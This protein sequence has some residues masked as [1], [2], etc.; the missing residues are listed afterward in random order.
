MRLGIVLLVGLL[1]WLIVLC[2]KRFVEIRRKQALI[3]AIPYYSLQKHYGVAHTP[4]LSVRILA[5][6]SPDCKQCHTMQT[7]ALRRVSEARA[8]S[9]EVIQVD[10]TTDVELAK[11]YRVLTVPSTII[12]DTAGHPHAVNYG[13][14]NTQRL[15]EQVDAALEVTASIE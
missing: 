2:G 10:A 1:A 8:D 14:A 9:V 7:P 4:S 6:S 11:R 5:F 12:L 3:S 15:L 13:F